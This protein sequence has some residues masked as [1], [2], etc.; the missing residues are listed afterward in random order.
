M[1][2]LNWLIPKYLVKAIMPYFIFA[3]LLLSVI[4]FLQQASRYS[5][6]FFNINIPAKLI[7]QLALALVPNVI[8]FTCP[9]AILVGTVIGLSKMQGD[10]ELVVLRASGVSNLQIMAPIALLGIVFSVFAF[11]VNLKG[12]PFAATLVRK[13]ALE[14]ALQKL[15]SPVEPGIFNTEIAGYTIY[16]QDG[17]VESGRWSDIFIY[18]ESQKDGILRLITAK[19]GRIGNSG[20][21][22][23]LV[24]ENTTSYTI[25][26]EPGQGKYVAENIGEVRFSIQTRRA[27]L[28]E[29]LNSSGGRIE[30][31]GLSEL[32][33]FAAAAEGRNR[34]DAQILWQRRLILSISPLIFSLL[35]ASM[36][37]RFNRGGRGFGTLLALAGLLGY[38]T[39]AF[40]GE[41]LARGGQINVVVGGMLPLVASAIAILWFNYSWRIN[42][43]RGLLDRA[44][45]LMASL[46]TSS[47]ERGTT[48]N[49]L[50]D[51]TTGLRDLDILLDLTGY[52]L[53]TLSFLVS[54]VIIFTAFDLWR[55]AGMID[56]G[57]ILLG[58]YLFYLLPF[59]YLQ[60][61]PSAAMIATL[62]TYVIKSRRNEI[63]VW[64]SAGQSIYRLLVPCFTI[65]L[66]LGI[67]DWQIQ[68]HV[69]PVTNQIQDA[70]RAQIMN[71]GMPVAR[72]SKYWV[73]NGDHIYS[74]SLASDNE[75]QSSSTRSSNAAPT[76]AGTPASDNDTAGPLCP[77]D[78][79]KNIYVYEFSKGKTDLQFLDRARSGYWRDGKVTLLGKTERDDLTGS[80]V[81]PSM[82][83]GLSIAE[84][85]NPFDAIRKKPGHLTSSELR[86]QLAT[87][88][89]ETERRSFNVTLQKRYETIFLPFVIALF[90]A[91]FALSLS[92]K[93]KAE[94]VGYAV[95]I[96]LLFAG[97]SVFFEQFGISG[98]LTPV[99]AV[100]S[101]LVLFT[102]FGVYLLTKVRT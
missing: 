9:M 49:L 102:T 2:R 29:R 73:A 16:V 55:F 11:V 67:L 90:T 45:G 92:R 33:D 53:L 62:A 76:S 39:L 79:V 38:F 74:F 85:A 84:G 37:L 30:E 31:L 15:D 3:W 25:P 19:N 59:V 13:I 4:L 86:S 18:A 96:G 101:P 47:P 52:F 24:L 35:G 26:L 44:K 23:E 50:V 65:M 54:I 68:E 87:S 66:L 97:V 69:V 22:S 5:D 56:G 57:E 75:Q 88:D 99:F 61:A 80:K 70:V 36:I 100:W 95:G 89:S 72:Q 34:I 64:T 8:A 41:L 12:V 77:Y 27:E 51:L 98:S 7:W 6:I 94:T 58:R 28:I 43:S 63:V 21:Q 46:R 17:D 82:I 78:C 60:I 81:E 10:S 1:T 42:F 91:P 20:D 32:S 14:T 71:R 93:G 48:R 83:D 40:L